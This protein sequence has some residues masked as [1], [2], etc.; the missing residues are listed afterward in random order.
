MEQAAVEAAIGKGLLVGERYY[1]Y[2]NDMA[3]DYSVDGKVEFI[4]SCDL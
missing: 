4:E 3:I 1:Y 2:N